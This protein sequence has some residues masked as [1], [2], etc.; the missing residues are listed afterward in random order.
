M[1]I[2]RL[3]AIGLVLS[4]CH[5]DSASSTSVGTDFTVAFFP[6]ASK[7]ITVPVSSNIYITSANSG[8]CNIEY[9][10]DPFT[11]SVRYVE[12]R[13]QQTTKVV[14]PIA[15]RVS[16]GAVREFSA[17]RIS[18]SVPVSAYASYST[19]G[20]LSSAML[21][22]PMSSLSTTYYVPGFPG[23]SFV[24]IVAT[25]DDTKVHIKL[26]SVT[27]FMYGNK[28]K[29]SGD[30]IDEILS[31][32]EVLFLHSPASDFG[33]TKITSNQPIAVFSGSNKIQDGG[34]VLSDEFSS[35]QA[36]PLHM[37]GTDFI[38]K[39]PLRSTYTRRFTRILAA[40][41][42]TVVNKIA[43]G[44]TQSVFT[45]LRQGS[46]TEDELN[47]TDTTV[48]FSS[49]PISVTVIAY[50][51]HGASYLPVPCL[52]LYQTDTQVPKLDSSDSYIF[53]TTET[54][55]LQGMQ[56]NGNSP[57]GTTWANMSSKV[58]PYSITVMPTTRTSSMTLQQTSLLGDFSAQIFGFA[59]NNK[60]FE[61]NV[62]YG[63][64]TSSPGVPGIEYSRVHLTCDRD[65]W[66]ITLNAT[67]FNGGLDYRGIFNNVTLGRDPFCTGVLQGDRL[68]LNASLQDCNTKTETEKGQTVY[69]NSLTFNQVW[70]YNVMCSLATTNMSA[71]QPQVASNVIDDRL[72]SIPTVTQIKLFS[73]YG[74][75]HEIPGDLK[76][77][78]GRTVYVEVSAPSDMGLSIVVN[79]CYTF[80]RSDSTIPLRHLIRNRCANDRSVGIM[81]TSAYRRRFSFTASSN[82]LEYVS[83]DVQFCRTNDLSEP[84]QPECVFYLGG[85]AVGR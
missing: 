38:I 67:A 74:F 72:G 85:P 80:D 22:L 64:S 33:G 70:Q 78:T 36:L 42:S 56:I 10:V 53:I 16:L 54:K 79:D 57:V 81:S 2:L 83:C 35:A 8:Y 43:G 59:A 29:V 51:P 47:S 41:N 1:I 18:C 37:W 55:E 27:R 15:A 13:R 6:Y 5:V 45:G 25:S 75:Q 32:N 82:T 28:A 65:R 23:N 66:E 62:G 69:E 7:N 12:V 4:R 40:T 21:I 44:V 77:V 63:V 49:N 71:A 48:Y 76:M 52:A 84:C 68:V 11:R 46:Y 50:G 20:F 60:E 24:G 31:E 9:A 34:F 58:L 17:I 73:D 3:A 39:E 26:Q 30:Y 19:S 14:I 61:A